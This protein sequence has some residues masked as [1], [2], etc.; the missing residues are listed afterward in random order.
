[1]DVEEEEE[2]DDDIPISSVRRRSARSTRTTRTPR[3]VQ[4]PSEDTDEDDA[5]ITSARPS[6]HKVPGKTPLDAEE[7]SP[8]LLRKSRRTRASA[9]LKALPP[10]SRAQTYITLSDSE[11]E[12]SLAAKP[13]QVEAGMNT[14][15]LH[16]SVARS[17]L[18]NY[19]ALDD[20][21]DEDDQPEFSGVKQHFRPA[22]IDEGGEDNKVP[23]LPN[24]QEPTLNTMEGKGKEKQVMEPDHDSDDELPL[25]PR[26]RRPTIKGKGKQKQVIESSDDS[27]D[28]D[29]FAGPSTKRRPSAAAKRRQSTAAQKAKDSDAQPLSSPLKRRKPVVESSDSDIDPSPTKRSR[30]TRGAKGQDNI[31][32]GDSRTST[33]ISRGATIKKSPGWHA[34]RRTTCR[35]RHRTKQEKTRELIRRRRAG[36]KIEKVTSS[37]SSDDAGNSSQALYDSDQELAVLKEF[38]D[39]EV[40]PEDQ[41][42]REAGRV[43][44]RRESSAS[45][46]NGDDD[47]D[48]DDFIVQDDSLGMNFH[49]QLSNIYYVFDTNILQVFPSTSR[50]NSRVTLT[51]PSRTTSLTVSNGLFIARSIWNFL[52]VTT[53]GTSTHSPRSTTKLADTQ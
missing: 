52:I 1:V 46:A 17:H 16:P 35:P 36:E 30:P 3:G 5:F 39:E 32:E 6:T 19:A 14:T 44:D 48:L 7:N 15:R 2:D 45:N 23:I 53:S 24:P 34:T 8:T 25:L 21:E 41:A 40:G 11:D 4:E 33:S 20:E 42:G 13:K 43:N 22:I 29:V 26:R 28:D 51:S 49:L 27:D 38:I 10:Q 47:S 37:S 31:N 9:P 12:L 18:R 50:F